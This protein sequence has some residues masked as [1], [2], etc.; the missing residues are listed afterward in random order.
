VPF[1]SLARMLADRG[2]PAGKIRLFPAPAQ[3]APASVRPPFHPAAAPEP[4][5]NRAARGR[6]AA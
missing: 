2:V 3:A 4:G 5:W 6:G 1:R